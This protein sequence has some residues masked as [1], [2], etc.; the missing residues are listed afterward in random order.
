VTSI[1]D[2]GDGQTLISGSYDKKIN[3]YNYKKSLLMY[4][5]ANNKSSV[6][7]III[8]G[9]RTKLLSCGLDNTLYVWNIIRKNDVIYI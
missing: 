1:L 2:L 5:L 8:N 4:N 6:T 9:N 3:V 7:G